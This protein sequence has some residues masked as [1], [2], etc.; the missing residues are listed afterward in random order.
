MKRFMLLWLLVLTAACSKGNGNLMI[1]F[2]ETE[3]D[4]QP[5]MTR[6]IITPEYMRFD[7][8]KDD[9]DFILFDRKS[10]IIYS[11]VNSDK[12]IVVIN[13]QEV[14]VKSPIKLDFSIEKGKLGKDV[15]EVEGKTPEYY[16]YLVNG[17]VCYE[18]ISVKGLFPDASKAFRE[19]LKTLAGE[20][21]RILP[22]TPADVQDPCDLAA[23]IYNYGSLYDKG[24]PINEWH[25]AYSNH[26][27]R[28]MIN[29]VRDYKPDPKLFELPKDYHR[30]T[31]EQLAGG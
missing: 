4:I 9:D 24:F 5:Y 19:Y 3:K 14:K 17:Q 7:Y 16:R 13:P 15:P 29:F 31:P 26:Y 30:Y 12:S 18:T 6:T 11:V 8:N 21:A 2:A 27:K 20:H 25:G 1:Q 23:N 28:Q 22:R 10:R